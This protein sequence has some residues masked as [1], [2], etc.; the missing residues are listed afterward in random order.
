LVVKAGGV[1]ITE[2][3]VLA[4][5]AKAFA[6]WQLPDDVI[7]VEALPLTSTGKLDKKV[8]RANL[9]DSDYQLPDLRS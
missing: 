7:F 2:Q 9:G 1:A 5:C 8:I 6:K 4:H 3:D